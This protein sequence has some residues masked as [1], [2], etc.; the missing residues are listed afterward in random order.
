MMELRP[1]QREAV[2]AVENGWNEYGK[3]LLVL[4]T[5]TGKTIVFSTIAKDESE[6]GRVLI[7]A[8]RDELISQAQDKYRMLTGDNTAKEKAGDSCLGSS[9]PVVVGSVQTLQSQRRLDKFPRDYFNTIIIDEAH[10][11]VSKSYQ[12]VINHFDGA[13]LLGVTA[14]PDRGDKKKLSDIFDK[15]AYTYSLKQAINDGYLCP[16]HAL[17]VPLKIDLSNVKVRVGDFEVNSVA[18]TLRP[19]LPQ[20]AEEIIDKAR[21]RKTV[22]FLPLISIAQELAGMIPGAREVNGQS[23]DRAETL[24][25][26]DKAGPGSV[27]CNA[28]LLT[29]GW[30]CP[31]CD[32]V[33][34]LRP[35]K[36]RALYTQMVG[37]GTRLSPGKKDL[38][39]LDFLWMTEK[40]NLCEPADLATDNEEDAKFIKSASE[41]G[42]IDLFGAE[43]D[44]V[45]SRRN[46]LAKK[47]KDNIGKESQ[48]IDPI[49]WA[50]DRDCMR[51]IA[52]YQPIFKWEFKPI[53]EKQM[54]W[55]KKHKFNPQGMT[56]GSVSALI[57]AFMKK[58]P[59]ARWQ[60]GRLHYQMGWD[61]NDTAGLSYEEANKIIFAK[62]EE[63]DNI[64][65]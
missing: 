16:I 31:S 52:D 42:E 35:T 34:V 23:K 13:K 65:W 54:A 38:L 25:W 33:V 27:L 57:N 17:T 44:A 36:I 5:G 18:E 30:D 8:H 41:E 2:E 59:I 60:R 40:H 51:E 24:E 19:L 64:P 63:D 3:L 43:S 4:P 61:W 46:S 45:E 7:L 22:V 32:C 53:T 50:V 47:L 1:Y 14:T 39:L 62:K 21:N 11:S 20:I 9:L 58:E 28:M 12:N 15:N 56:R 29:E 48:L 10:H 55:L 6:R 26:F 49:N 37:R